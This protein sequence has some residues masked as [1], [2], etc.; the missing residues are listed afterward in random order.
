MD[1]N[2]IRPEQ[3]VDTSLRITLLPDNFKAYIE[4]IEK[5]VLHK[6]LSKNCF[7][8]RHTAGALG[9]SYDQLRGYLRKYDLIE[10]KTS[11]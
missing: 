7:H 3:E 6:A 5:E 1:N 2:S 11:S 4:T 8:Q 9:L 10:K